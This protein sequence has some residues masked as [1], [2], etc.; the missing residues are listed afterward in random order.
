MLV[1]CSV[2]FPGVLMLMMAEYPNLRVFT[3]LPG[4]VAT[5]MI[6]D[7][8]KPFAKDDPKMLGML[9]TYLASP[10][11]EYLRG[12][13]VSVNWDIKEME[14]Y[15][16]DIEKKGLLKMSWVPVLPISGGEGLVG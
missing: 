10:K 7:A 8:F 16:D 9:A 13:L 11:A 14:N 3:T 2:P 4:I 1:G 5:E 15:K 6:A 12:Q